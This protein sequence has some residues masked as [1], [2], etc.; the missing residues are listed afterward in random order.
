MRNI[1]GRLNKRRAGSAR[2]GF[3]LIELL[4]GGSVMLLVILG[5][6]SI[7]MKSNKVAVEQNM[8]AEMQHDVRSGMYFISRDTRMAG[9]GLTQDMADYFV[10]GKDGYGT[11]PE[12]SDM[13][14]LFGN[15]DD[16]LNLVVED[17]H[18][19]Q[20]GGSAE[21]KLYDWSL[22]NSPYPCP[23]YYEN[24]TVLV[25]S[26]RCPGCWAF[27]YIGNNSVHGCNSN[28]SDEHVNMQP[29][30]S[31]LNPPGGLVDPGVCPADCWIDAIITVGQVRQYWL[32]TTGNPGDYA[33][34]TNLDSAHGY[35]GIPYTLY[36]TT[37][38]EQG[39]VRHL[40]VAQNIENLQ[41][42]Y[43]A[44]MDKD[45]LLDGFVDWNDAWTL[46]QRS[47]IQQVRIWVLGRTAA[48]FTSVS[49]SPSTA[50]YLY[51]R[52]AVANSHVVGQD[53]RRKRFLLDSTASIRNLSMNIYNAGTR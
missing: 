37:M 1:F 43:N 53:D 41:F 29:G 45:G 3:T 17:Y 22:E 4:I 30:N 52:P 32:D 18:G 21:A 26:T 5:S 25:M 51:R 49:G 48:P 2:R 38:D 7:Y 44:D 40:P 46:D 19:G 20:G 31:D 33:G 47:Q 35:T 24:R 12:S 39:A 14:K 23:D 15:F 28:G 6:L 8:Y 42:Q 27:R 50:V 16:P 11:A 13:I 9:V 10:E 34:L 36:N